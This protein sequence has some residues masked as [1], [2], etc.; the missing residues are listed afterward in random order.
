V[1][2]NELFISGEYS[3]TNIF[4]NGRAMFVVRL[5]ADGTFIQ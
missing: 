3:G 1:G 5:K 2:N 4:Q